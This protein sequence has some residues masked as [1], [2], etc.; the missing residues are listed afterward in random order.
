MCKCVCAHVCVGSENHRNMCSMLL[1]KGTYKIEFKTFLGVGSGGGLITFSAHRVCR[2]SEGKQMLAIKHF[3]CRNSV[4]AARL[5]HQL[6]DV[7][8]VR[9]PDANQRSFS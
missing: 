6:G 2:L 9:F 8:G 3:V 5:P 1:L 7:L 4:G